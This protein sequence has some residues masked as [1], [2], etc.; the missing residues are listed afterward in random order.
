[1]YSGKMLSELMDMV[2]RAEEHAKQIKVDEEQ[3][4]PYALYVS[5]LI[6]DQATQHAMMGAA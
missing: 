2:A 3:P 1:M 5:R 4:E 6:Y